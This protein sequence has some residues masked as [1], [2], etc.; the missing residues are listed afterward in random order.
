M[1]KF[2]I[3]IVLTAYFQFKHH[4]KKQT[5]KHIFVAIY[6]NYLVVKKVKT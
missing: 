4:H 2:F 1:E 3:D 6:S 5:E